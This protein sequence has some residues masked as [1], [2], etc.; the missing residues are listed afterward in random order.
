M[1]GNTKTSAALA[2]IKSLQQTLDGTDDDAAPAADANAAPAPVD[3]A[4]D[5]TSTLE[6]KAAREILNSVRDA[7]NGMAGDSAL[8]N[9]LV[10]PLSSD[11]LPLDGAVEST[12]DDYEE[13]P[14]SHFGLAM[15]RGMGWKDEDKATAAAKKAAEGPVL[16]PKGMGLG[17]DKMIK[18]KP[19]LVQPAKGEVLEVRKGASVRILSGK[20]KDSYGQVS[21]CLVDGSFDSIASANCQTESKHFSRSVETVYILIFRKQIDWSVYRYKLEYSQNS[22]SNH[23]RMKLK[24]ESAT[25]CVA[26]SIRFIARHR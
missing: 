15:L 7:Q 11:Q 10:L 24:L 6:Q 23:I 18:A 20:R 5:A 13:I 22:I 4:T 16:R 26:L 9:S 8:A 1:I 19:L 14:I 17:A 25:T 2:A 3:N 21:D 12:A